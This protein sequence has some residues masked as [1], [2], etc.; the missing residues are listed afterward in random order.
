MNLN[1]IVEN[2]NPQQPT[3]KEFST[4]FMM[5][6]ACNTII[7]MDHGVIPACTI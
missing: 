1:F 5:I 7:N 2:Q 4:V 3:S 6:L